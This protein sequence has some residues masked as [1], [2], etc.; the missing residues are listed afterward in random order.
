MST[1]LGNAEK[2]EKSSLS[3]SD[4]KTS[5]IPKSMGWD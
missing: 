2:K 5:L 4:D 1:F 3:T